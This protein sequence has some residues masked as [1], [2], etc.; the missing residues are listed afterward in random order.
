MELLVRVYH[1]GASP[2]YGMT[3]VSC[4]FCEGRLG[5]VP[6]CQG[7]SVLFHSMLQC[8]SCLANVN[9]L[10]VAAWDPVDHSCPLVPGDVVFETHQHPLEGAMWPK[11]GRKTTSP[12]TN[13]QEWSTGSHA[14]TV[15]RSTMAKQEEHWSIE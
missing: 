1:L 12:G 7:S 9:L 3:S 10:A 14:A 11:A 5:Q 6:T 4:M 13:G 15:S 8:S 2:I